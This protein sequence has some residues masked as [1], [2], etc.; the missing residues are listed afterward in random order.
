MYLGSTIRTGRFCRK[1]YKNTGYK[2]CQTVSILNERNAPYLVIVDSCI[3][4]PGQADTVPVF[5]N[6]VRRMYKG[7]PSWMSPGIFC[8]SM[9]WLLPNPCIYK[10]IL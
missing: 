1:G 9:K 8:T 3:S 6:P 10:A 7:H 5:L 2:Q 4:E